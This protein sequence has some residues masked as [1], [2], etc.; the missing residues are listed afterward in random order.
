MTAYDAINS[1]D[2][3]E[4]SLWFG[5]DAFCQINLLTLLAYLEQINYRGKVTLNYID[6]ET[7]CTLEKG[8][9]VI[10]GRYKSL[11]EDILVHG[12]HP[13][14]TGVLV[15]DS[16]DLYFDYHSENG[17]LARTVREHADVSKTEL[18]CLLL[19]ISKEYGLSDVQAEGLI[20]KYRTK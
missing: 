13:K 20:Q 3:T 6:D 11:Y 7:F 4:L 14:N 18:I 10:L 16:I 2:Y 5:K 8:I 9:P 15:P 1:T 17:M 12:R 19:R